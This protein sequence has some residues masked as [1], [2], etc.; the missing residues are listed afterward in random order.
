[1][2]ALPQ[3]HRPLRH[4]AVLRADRAG[5]AVA[6]V[7]VTVEERRPAR[8]P[9]AAPHRRAR[10]SG[11][12]GSAS[13][14]GEI[15]RPARDRAALRRCALRA[16]GRVARGRRGRRRDPRAVRRRRPD[17]V[18]ASCRRTT[19]A[20][21]TTSPFALAQA[22]RARG[23]ARRHRGRRRRRR[24]RGRGRARRRRC[25][26]RRA[27]TPRLTPVALDVERTPDG[28]AIAGW[29][30]LDHDPS[31]LL[32]LADPFSS[33]STTSSRARATTGPGARR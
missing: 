15:G 27:P 28:A 12:S 1:M 9:I 31:T 4:R 8:T 7:P 13:S 32:L 21:S 6:E 20:R 33:R 24:R 5:L 2:R 11:S 10:W 17:L 19:S 16:P 22:A 29:P 3:R 26:R 25:S 14:S 30:D 18:V 23:D